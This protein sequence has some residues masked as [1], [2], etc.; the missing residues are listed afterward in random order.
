[1]TLLTLRLLRVRLRGL[2]TKANGEYGKGAPFWGS[3]NRGVWSKGDYA[4][5]VQRFFQS[6]PVLYL[7][8]L[9]V[10]AGT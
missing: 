8:N 4:L 2:T 3:L 10:M 9:W 7:G 5:A 1:M 6:R